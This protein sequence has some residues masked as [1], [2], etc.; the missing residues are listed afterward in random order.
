MKKLSL[1]LF[2]LF[3]LLLSLSKV[4]H[5]QIKRIT[6]DL[7]KMTVTGFDSD[8]FEVNGDI[9]FEINNIWG[10]SQDS[11]TITYSTYD[12]DHN[13]LQSTFTSLL[14]VSGAD[15][16]KDSQTEIQSSNDSTIYGTTENS[17]KVK[18]PRDYIIFQFDS[19]AVYS[20]RTIGNLIKAD[21]PQ[22]QFSALSESVLTK[23]RLWTPIKTYYQLPIQIGDADV[24][25]I[26]ITRYKRRTNI[27]VDKQTY[28]YHNSGGSGKIDFSAGFFATGL[29]NEQYSLLGTTQQDTVY[30]IENFIATDSIT[31]INPVAKNRIIKEEEGNFRIGVGILAHYH[32]RRARSWNL[33][34]SAGFQIDNDV[35]VGYLVGGSLFLGKKQRLIFT[36]GIALAQVQQLSNRYSSNDLIETSITA[37]QLLHNVWKAS[38]FGGISYNF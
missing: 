17:T 16:V 9:H 36:S 7:E 34:L 30:H 5:S 25:K 19:T 21:F 12:Y 24:S 35:K 29:V 11:L 15:M 23:D 28:E 22:L 14:G 1:K 2:L 27:V 10:D 33:G 32:S 31:A 38:W 3:G 26:E 6:I 4:M 8:L 13:G 20:L 37:D 18:A